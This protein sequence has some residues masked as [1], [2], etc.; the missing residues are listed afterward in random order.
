[1]HPVPAGSAFGTCRLFVEYPPTRPV[2]SDMCTGCVEDCRRGQPLSMRLGA[3]LEGWVDS[4]AYLCL[5]KLPGRAPLLSGPGARCSLPAVFGCHDERAAGPKGRMCRDETSSL[6]RRRGAC[7]KAV[8]RARREGRRDRAERSAGGC[9]CCCCCCCCCYGSWGHLAGV[10]KT[11]GG[12]LQGWAHGLGGTVCSKRQWRGFAK[13]ATGCA[14]VMAAQEERAVPTR[15]G[16]EGR[17]KREAARS[18]RGSRGIGT[19]TSSS[20][21]VEHARKRERRNGPKRCRT[22][23]GPLVAASL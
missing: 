4:D 23:R 22:A 7:A 14:L 13:T 18:G 16:R 20:R 6:G 11:A 3:L 10:G 17:E 19:R 21:K 1:M 12:S 9:C 15:E 8:A 5:T 2:L